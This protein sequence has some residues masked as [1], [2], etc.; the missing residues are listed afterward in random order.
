MAYDDYLYFMEIAILLCGLAL[1]FCQ[2]VKANSSAAV[3]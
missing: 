2:K 3:H 1:I